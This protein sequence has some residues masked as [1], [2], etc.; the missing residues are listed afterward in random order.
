MENRDAILLR[1]V[2]QGSKLDVEMGPLWRVA[3]Y[4][5]ANEPDSSRNTI[6]AL[7]VN[8]TL[9]DGRGALALFGALFSPNVPDA[10]PETAQKLPP[11]LEE[12]IDCRP[13]FTK[14]LRVV[15]SELLLPALPAILRPRTKLPWPGVLPKVPRDC[16]PAFMS[17]AFPQ[18]I[19]ESLKRAARNGNIK[20]IH[21]ILYTASLC[22]LLASVDSPDQEQANGQGLYLSTE[23]PISMRSTDLGHPAFTGN[24]VADHLSSHTLQP[25]TS[26]WSLAQQYDS[27]LNSRPNRKIALENIGM[28][29]YIPDSASHTSTAEEPTGWESYLRSKAERRA[30]F[31]A[32]FEI[33]NLGLLAISPP[34]STGATTDQTAPL[35]DL[36]FAQAPSP[37]G[38]SLSINI[39][40]LSS[41][42]L[43]IVL[44]WKEGVIERALVRR[45]AHYF[46][47]ALEALASG[48]AEGEITLGQIVKMGEED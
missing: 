3:R 23:T 15:A 5:S 17:L 16:P 20:T 43:S 38:N 32:S 22:A 9:T 47:T 4:Q 42:G 1:E 40:G 39:I 25:S 19:V 11:T 10:F 36:Y 18:P 30:P 2:E 37:I 31:R 13:S 34:V 8:H 29:A 12:T 24:Y 14:L 35:R 21:P 33:S 44:G 45:F 26:F 7:T 41:S 6:V 46:R 28:L 27:D 48:N